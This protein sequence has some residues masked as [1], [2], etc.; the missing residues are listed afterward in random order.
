MCGMQQFLDRLL[1]QRVFPQQFSGVLNV[2]AVIEIG[3]PP[4]A[5]KRRFSKILH[6]ALLF[7]IG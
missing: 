4:A 5:T 1:E 3:Q 7:R 2:R 6:P